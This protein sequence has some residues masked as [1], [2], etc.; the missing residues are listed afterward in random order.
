MS[1]SFAN[2]THTGNYTAEDAKGK[3]NQ[4]S[5]ISM[6]D[7]FVQTM[8]REDLPN[9]QLHVLADGHGPA[10]HV[11]SNFIIEKY[12]QILSKYLFKVITEIDIL[13]R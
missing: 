3:I 10:G 8:S 13:K 2:S 6:K 9:Y 12:P 5:R 11:I 1:I 7:L 4:D